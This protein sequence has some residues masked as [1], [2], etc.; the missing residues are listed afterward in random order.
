MSQLNEIQQRIVDS[1]LATPPQ[2]AE[3]AA[4]FQQ[5]VAA[6]DASGDRFLAWLVERELL[7]EF[8]AEALAA[9][10]CGPFLLGPYRVQ[11]HLAVGR[12]GG[13]FRAV[14]DELAQAVTLNVFPAT[15]A[16]QPDKLAQIG[17]EARIFLEL[18]HENVV[19]SF[20]VGQV[21]DTYYLVLQELRG[22]TLA[23]RLRRNGRMP[24]RRACRLV[25]DIARGLQHLHTNDVLHRDL[26]PEHIWLSENDR[27]QIMEFG[28]ARDAL[29][30]VDELPVDEPPTGA[31]PDD[32]RHGEAPGAA[33]G[34]WPDVEPGYYDYLAPEQSLDVQLADARSDIYSV[35]C[36]LYHCL[37][38]RPPFEERNQLKLALSHALLEP[39]H[40]SLDLD[41]LPPQVEE[42]LWAMLAKSPEQRFQHAHEVAFALDQYAEHPERAEQVQVLAVSSE[43]L[44]WCQTAYPAD[45]GRIPRDSV[46]VTPELT[47][48]L[49]WLER[50]HRRRRNG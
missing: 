37:T 19:R 41:D 33:L 45:S 27:P 13:L 50:R 46:G 47:E 24:Y 49:G 34:Y 12:L 39:R 6:A 18:D 7:T 32:A 1:Q 2:A 4:R 26:R 25:R 15:L 20:H 17:R 48:F 43:Y 5:D 23:S 29:A 35:G 30:H 40:P 11:E 21:A 36:I 9:G 42:T 16:R 44:D 28:A 38:G 3:Y 31:R 8:Q 10:H 14:H 22:E